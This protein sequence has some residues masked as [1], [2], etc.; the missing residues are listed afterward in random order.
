[1][2]LPLYQITAEVRSLLDTG[3]DEETG[4][5]TPALNTALTRFE[6]KGADVAAYVLNVEAEAEAVRSAIARLTNRKRALESRAQR[7][8]DYL[9]E[10]MAAAGITRID[11]NDHSFSVRLDRDR[12]ESIEVEPD[13]VLPEQFQRVRI[14]PDK[15]AL[16]K[17]L[18]AG[19]PIPQGVR[20]VR[21]DRL[22]IA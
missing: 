17:A 13:A 9:R 22:T 1:M 10:N 19:E 2:S 18:K 21:H 7:M 8:R 16:R 5:M 11:A 6:G 4:E 20:L 14:E 15:A 3:F 12:D